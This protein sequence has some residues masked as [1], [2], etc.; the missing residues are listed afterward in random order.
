[1]PNNKSK[2]DDVLAVLLAMKTLFEGGYRNIGFA[3]LRQDAVKDIAEREFRGKRY[4]TLDSAMKTIHDACARRLRPEVA[5]IR[6]FDEMVGQWLRKK[7]MVIRDV[8]VKHS[9]TPSQ[10]AMVTGF[11]AKN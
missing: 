5:S 3:E 10:R 9:E 8:L 2:V 11:F 4:K 7:S 6:D 1:M